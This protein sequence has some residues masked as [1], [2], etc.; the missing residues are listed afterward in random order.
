MNSTRRRTRVFTVEKV[1]RLIDNDP[2][3]WWDVYAKT[4]IHFT[5]GRG[6][7]Y[8]KKNAIYNRNWRGENKWGTARRI[9]VGSD[10]LFRL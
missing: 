6:Q 3:Y 7:T 8:F 2:H 5:E 4:L 9:E 10:G 1:D